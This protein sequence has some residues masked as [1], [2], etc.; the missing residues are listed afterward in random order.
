[1]VE[2]SSIKTI[3]LAGGKGTRLY[4]LLVDLPKPML[5]IKGKPLLYHIMHNAQKYGFNEFIFK[6]CY[7]SDKIEDYFG[8]GSKFGCKIEYFIEKEPLGTAGGLNYLKHSKNIYIVLF[9]DVILNLNL[10]KMLEF[11]INNKSQ[12]TLVVHH[13][14]HPEDS[15]VVV[16]DEKSRIIKTI[17]KPGNR[18]Y[19]DI[20]NAALYI[21]NSECFS[22]IPETGMFDFGKEMVPKLIAEK[23]KVYGYMS[24][25]YM[26]DVGTIHR[27]EEVNREIDEGK[28]FNKVEAVFI[29][30]D[31]TINKEVNLLHKI[32]DFELLEG[33]SDAIKIFND[34]NIPVIVVTNQPVVARNLCDESKVKEIHNHMINELSKEGTYIDEVYY[35]PHHPEKNHPDGNPKY[36]ID[37]EC[38]KPKI[39]MLL[40]A[41]KKF[42]LDL[43]K[44]FMIGDT[45]SDIQTAKN[46][47]CK[48]ILVKTG[49]GGSDKKIDVKPDYIFD[50]LRDAAKFIE[51]YNKQHIGN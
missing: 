17:H 48:S 5:D 39:G 34:S 51:K 19:G 42:G 40:E 1:M 45:T 36:R 50:N 20:T 4:P 3:I 10:R 35:C 49:Y 26:K 47:G 12:A 22:L 28:V 23:Y 32:E 14:N 24:D 43:K 37:C 15:D 16:L 2:H 13:S 9:G 11:H 29:D 27:H 46:A 31:G 41:Q 25:E 6:T 30:R 18:D 7:M 33:T 8:N 38:R 44:C 21:L